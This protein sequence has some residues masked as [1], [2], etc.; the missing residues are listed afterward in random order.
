MPDLAEFITPSGTPRSIFYDLPKTATLN[1]D[2]HDPQEVLFNRVSAEFRGGFD[3][4][5]PQLLQKV[6]SNPSS[7][8][9]ILKKLLGTRCF[10]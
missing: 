2:T 7:F 4:D 1:D 5:D 9:F 6:T 10:Q 8:F 3:I